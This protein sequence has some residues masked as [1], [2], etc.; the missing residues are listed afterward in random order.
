MVYF[1][2]V[3]AGMAAALGSLFLSIP[4]T[5]TIAAGMLRS[6]VASIPTTHDGIEFQRSVIDVSL[7]PAT[8]VALLAFLAGFSWMLRRESGI[9]H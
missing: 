9:K 3:L 8:G 1:K 6:R 5:L 2:S 7:G 4:V